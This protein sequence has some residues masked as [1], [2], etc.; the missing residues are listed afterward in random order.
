MGNS[1]NSKPP[2]DGNF[3]D[4]NSVNSKQLMRIDEFALFLMNKHEHLF[5]DD[6]PDRQ[7]IVKEEIKLEDLDIPQIYNFKGLYY[8]IFKLDN[9]WHIR[10]MR[11]NQFLIEAAYAKI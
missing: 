9:K 8:I 3:I 11:G 1:N 6:I 7:I 4:P 10:I 5:R 2:N